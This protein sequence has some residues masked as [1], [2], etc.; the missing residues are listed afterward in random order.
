MA[1]QKEASAS[2]EVQEMVD[3]RRDYKR[4]GETG[5]SHNLKAVQKINSSGWTWKDWQGF[6]VWMKLPWGGG[7]GVT[8]LGVFHRLVQKSVLRTVMEG[9]EKEEGGLLKAAQER[10]IIKEGL[11]SV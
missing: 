10:K 6:V 4:Q 1:L 3:W 5:R 11:M 7:G 8:H 9:V 2:C